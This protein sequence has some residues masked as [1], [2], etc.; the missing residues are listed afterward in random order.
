[1]TIQRDINK[2]LEKVDKAVQHYKEVSDCDAFD[3]S[4]FSVGDNVYEK[5]SEYNTFDQHDL[6]IGLLETVIHL[7]G[8]F[9]ETV[10]KTK[11]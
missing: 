7:Q 5:H 2:Y 8:V 11:K 3:S 4:L 6:I 9:I 1:M 10:N